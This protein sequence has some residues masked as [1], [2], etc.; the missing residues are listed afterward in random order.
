MM[1]LASLPSRA[2]VVIVWIFNVWGT[3]DLLHAFYEA[4]AGGVI[5]GQ[6]GAAYFIPTLLVP[7]LLVTHVL[8]FRI[9]L[10]GRLHL[11]PYTLS[12]SPKA[13]RA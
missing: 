3:F 7:L 13:Y 9:L 1:S 2:G 8:I 10:R 4:N 5:P 11:K 6:L 12:V